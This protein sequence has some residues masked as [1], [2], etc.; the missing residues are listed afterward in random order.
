V[1]DP[2]DVCSINVTAKDLNDVK[3]E[4]FQLFDNVAYINAGE[5]LLPFE[6]FTH[7]PIVRELEMPLN[8]LRGIKI[9]LDDFPNL[10]VLDLSYNNLSKDD[11]LSLGTLPKLK[12]LYLTGNQ[13]RSLPV[14]MAKPYKVE[15][16]DDEETSVS[17][18]ASLELLSLD[19]N[20]LTD[21]ATFASLAGLP[22]LRRLHLDKNDISSVPHLR[23][24]SGSHVAVGDNDG[25]GSARSTPGRKKSGRRSSASSRNR[26]RASTAP[27]REASA[28][29]GTQQTSRILIKSH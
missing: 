4:D 25:A 26:S 14:E 1:E 17:R 27:P 7:F 15:M 5:N 18:F 23:A 10:E 9:E 11:I 16:K 19:D 3:S 29:P 28:E 20:H 21:L 8:A 22:R 6:A 12:V 2:S 13:L 24:L